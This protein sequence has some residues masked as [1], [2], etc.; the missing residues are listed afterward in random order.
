M[1]IQQNSLSQQPSGHWFSIK[2]NTEEFIV[3]LSRDAIENRFMNP[4]NSVEPK[5][6]YK[7]NRKL[8]DAVARRKFLQGFPRPITVVAADFS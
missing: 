6:A 5:L 1:A 3:L 7:K 2:I 4:G 8:I